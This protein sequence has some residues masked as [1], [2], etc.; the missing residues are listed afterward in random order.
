[1]SLY[2]LRHV[3][4]YNNDKGIISGQSEAEILPNQK[5]KFK[6]ECK[7]FDIIYSS[8][9]QRCRE[10]LGLF[11]S[12]TRIL[13][14]ETLLER[15]LGDLENMSKTDAIA[16]YPEL[17]RNNFLDIYSHIPNGETINDVIKRVMPLIDI[18]YQIPQ[19]NKC[20]LCSHNQLLKIIYAYILK[21]PITNDYWQQKNF[22]NGEIIKVM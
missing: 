12:N 18:I 17:F 4:T 16:K 15:S 13:Y 21:I 20:L 7:N 1:M 8:P 14:T 11:I 6:C 22:N 2:F 9:S 10:T 5:I 3:K 19:N